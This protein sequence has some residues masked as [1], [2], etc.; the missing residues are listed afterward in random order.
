[1]AGYNTTQ[2][3]MTAGRAIISALVLWLA[4]SGVAAAE[5]F[6]VNESGWWY[7]SGAFNASTAP[8][9]AAVDAAGAGETRSLCTTAPTTK[10]AP[11]G[12]LEHRNLVKICVISWLTTFQIYSFAL[13]TTHHKQWHVTSIVNHA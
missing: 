11:W 7:D 1:M 12:E 4:F 5:Q 8:I 13:T 10:V 6:Y 3:R 2:N 9:Q